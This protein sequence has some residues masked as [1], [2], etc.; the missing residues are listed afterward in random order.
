MREL[1]NSNHLLLVGLGYSNLARVL[2]PVTRFSGIFPETV[3]ELDFPGRSGFLSCGFCV[4]ALPAEF[5][6]GHRTAANV[7]RRH[8]CLARPARDEKTRS[9]LPSLLLLPNL[10]RL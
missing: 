1:G 9:R 6:P 7:G 10:M 8:D 2:A 5:Q 3:P 4:V